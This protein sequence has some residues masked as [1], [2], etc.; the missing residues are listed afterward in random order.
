MLRFSMLLALYFII[1]ALP[2]FANQSLNPDIA[3]NA[4]LEQHASMCKIRDCNQEPSK[5]W[6]ITQ[7]AF[8]AVGLTYFVWSG[9]AAKISGFLVKKT[10]Q[11]W[12]KY[13]IFS[14]IISTFW[15]LSVLFFRFCK[16]YALNLPFKSWMVSEYFFTFLFT[17]FALIFC[18]FGIKILFRRFWIVPASAVGAYFLTLSLPGQNTIIRPMPERPVTNTIKKMAEP[19]SI[20]PNNINQGWVTGMSLSSEGARA[21]GFAAN[22]NITFSETLFP[23][24]IEGYHGGESLPPAS[25][26]ILIAIAGHEIAHH[27]NNDII[28][29]TLFSCFA[30][31]LFS[32]L[33]M[34]IAV[35]LVEKFGYKAGIDSIRSLSC[36]P[37]YMS[38][39]IVGLMA[40][41]PLIA[42][43]VRQTE[44]RADKDGLEISR[45]P[46]GFAKAMLRLH[47]DKP[48]YGNS[49]Q[50]FMLDTHPNGRDR[51]YNAMVWKTKH[52]K[53]SGIQTK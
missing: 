25:D 51:I 35:R 37:F 43:A 48:L 27:A 41:Q 49:F 26:E 44:L 30:G 4:Y 34:F 1:S 52:F 19:F 23:N 15:F 18:S 46:D 11:Y 53:R 14:F 33:S 40:S 28:F 17:A 36:Y 29:L 45:A 32:G 16:N 24:N 6:E 47:V 13:F 8:I 7:Y 10:R 12:L 50:E 2:A 22:R 42:I 3:T 9:R 39:I 5:F 20:H 38:S 31:A 21:W